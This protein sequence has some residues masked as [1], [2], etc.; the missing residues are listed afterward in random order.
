VKDLTTGNPFRAI[1]RISLPI[2]LSV[3]FQQVGLAES[4]FAG[5]F[6][7]ES[8]LSAVGNASALAAFFMM[9][10]YGMGVGGSV[11][12]S[13]LFGGKDY[14]AV[15]RAV[16]TLAVS[17]ALFAAL[18]SAFGIVFCRPLLY[19]INT[20]DEIIGMSQTYLTVF[21]TGLGFMYIFNICSGVS[22][23]LGDSVTSCVLLLIQ[24][25][26]SI[27]LC[28]I[29]GKSGA[30]VAG[31]AAARVA[32][33]V[34]CT[35]PALFL[36][37]KKLRRLEIKIPKNE[38]FSPPLMKKLISNVI[39]AT[40]H[41]SVGSIG[42]MF[43][44][45]AVNP[46]G[47]SAIAGISVGSRIN[48]FASDCID[49]VP[50]GTSAFAAQNIGAGRYMRV[51]KGFR[52]GLFQVSV[53]SSLFAVIFIIWRNPIA[54]FFTG[55]DAPETIK[56]AALYISVTA[57]SFPLMGI[58]YLCDDILRAAGRMK[59]YLLTTVQNLLLRV[60]LVY[61]LTPILGAPAVGI[62]FAA[63][64]AVTAVVSIIIYRKQ[65]WRRGSPRRRVARLANSNC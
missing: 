57:L 22:T 5:R 55:T 16:S 65:F 64:T 30:G 31:L 4:F 63:A 45:A 61:A 36:I 60:G 51:K 23:A 37:I 26:L 20:P 2:F 49:S 34:L 10:A 62:A 44:Q 50:D 15:I 14:A 7:G 8:A 35:V 9:G 6:Y 18:I 25:I 27:T 47:M 24:N 13:H 12:V 17:G 40:L 21:L 32:T 54:A 41:T 42:N 39:P 58:K 56:T 28:F 53:L 38:L 52:A 33:Q 43:I 48:G 11:V 46:L 29:I 59:L 3:F 1:F 19:L